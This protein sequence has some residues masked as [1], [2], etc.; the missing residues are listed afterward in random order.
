MV[1]LNPKAKSVVDQLAK[2]G[3]VAV[4][5]ECSGFLLDSAGGVWNWDVFGDNVTVSRN[6]WRSRTVLVGNV[7]E[8]MFRWLF[9][10]ETTRPSLEFPITLEDAIEIFGV[11]AVHDAF[12]RF[13]LIDA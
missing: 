10:N 8:Y 12:K 2:Y 7:S 9:D 11:A 1:S 5:T 6:G 13:R 4:L 3:H